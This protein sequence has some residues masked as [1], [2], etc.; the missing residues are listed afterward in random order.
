MEYVLPMAQDSGSVAESRSARRSDH[1]SGTASRTPVSYQ[2]LP[3][4][5]GFLKSST[6]SRHVDVV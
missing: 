6:C 5:V 2:A 3:D 4:V 1:H